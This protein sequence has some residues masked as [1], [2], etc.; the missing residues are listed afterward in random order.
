M[1]YELP[2]PKWGQDILDRLD[3][4]PRVLELEKG[5]SAQK[6]EIERLRGQRTLLIGQLNDLKNELAIKEMILA[7][8]KARIEELETAVSDRY[9]VSLPTK[10][11]LP[12]QG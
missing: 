6:S 3:N 7:K 12:T 2:P 11:T 10:V 5:I 1:K 4:L 9:R 8:Q